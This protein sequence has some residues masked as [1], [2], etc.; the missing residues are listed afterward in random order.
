MILAGC[1]VLI[2]AT[3]PGVDHLP[4]IWAVRAELAGGSAYSPSLDILFQE[5]YSTFC[6][7]CVTA[8]FAYPLPAM[9]LALPVAWLPDFLAGVV[10]CVISTIIL[11]CGLALARLPPQLALFAPIW[12][13]VIQQQATVLIVGLLLIGIWAARE[14]RWWYL[15]IIIAL[16]VLTKPQTSM[17][18]A[19]VFAIQ[20]F[21]HRRWLPLILPSAAPLACTFIIE[22]LWPLEWLHAMQRYNHALEPRWLIHWTALVV[23]PVIFRRRWATLAILQMCLIPVVAN[24]YT[25]LPLL[26]GYV[27]LE[28]RWL[29]WI[30][31]GL[32]WMLLISRSIISAPTIWSVGYFLPFAAVLLMEHFMA[33]HGQRR[34]QTS[35]IDVSLQA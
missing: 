22:P 25:L 20:L 24:G 17:L 27:D 11:L 18:F 3:V 5:T 4:L 6:P 7:A 33:R 30:V 21:Q 19:C 13:G 28:R 12:Y 32:S 34:K 9:W 23:L 8:G 15:G 14:Q 35:M 31:V 16:T 2:G 10:W 1:L 29:T 26:I